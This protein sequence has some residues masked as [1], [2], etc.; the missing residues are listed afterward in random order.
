MVAHIVAM[1][2]GGFLMND[3]PTALD[4]Y[5]VSLAAVRT[6]EVCFLATASGDATSCIERFHAAFGQLDCTARHLPLFDRTE[7]D[8]SEVIASADV[9][10]VGGGSTANLLAVWRLHGVDRALAAFRRRR[11]G[12]VAGVSAGALCWF[13]GGVTDSFG[14]QLDPLY[15]GLCW[16]EGSFC[17]H[18]DGEVLRRPTYHRLVGSGSLPSGFAA[19]DGAALHV[20]DGVR[21]AIAERHAARVYRVE[22]DE[23]EA[24]GVR[25][26]ALATARI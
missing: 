2:G 6:P 13:E 4:A 26:T 1:G 22:R 24:G 19:D 18:F 25:Q 21:T 23:D 8:P 5:V 15:D 3:G 16:I 12:V 17:P 9:V 14:P 11:G 10:Y 7:E 20:D